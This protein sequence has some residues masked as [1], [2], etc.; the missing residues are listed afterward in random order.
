MYRA[1]LVVSVIAVF[2]G[3]LA[4][5]ADNSPDDSANISAHLQKDYPTMFNPANATLPH[6]FIA[7]GGDYVGQLW[8]WDSWLGDVALAQISQDKGGPASGN[9]AITYGEGCVLDFLHYTNADGFCPITVQANGDPKSYVPTPGFKTNMHKPVLA[10]H[11]AFLTQL[12][13]GDAEWLREAFPRLQAFLANYRTNSFDAD[14]GLY[15]WQDDAGIGVDNDP[16]TFYRPNGSS[17]SIFLNCLMYKELKAMAYLCASLKLPA[18]TGADYDKEA[19][20]LKTAIQKNCWDERDGF[21]YSVDLNLLPKNRPV[22]HYMCNYFSIHS[23]HPRDYPCLI[24]RIEIWSGFMAMWAGIATQD[25]AKRMVEE[26]LKNP[27]TFGAEYG[28]RSLSKMEKM[29]G[30]HFSSN[31]SNWQG[32]VWGVA[33]YMTFRGLLNYG[34]HHEAA[35]LADRTIKLFG[36]DFAKTG[37]IHES[38]N[39]DNGAPIGGTYQSWNYLVANMLAWKEHRTVVGEF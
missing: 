15:F 39:P 27:K 37:A 14:S 5:G 9:D 34:F 1:H 30:I 11:A 19:E 6:P 13:K 2:A 22:D 21:Y 29:Y 33:N 23:G 24:Q 3:S 10:Q 36:Q 16:C 7:P 12:N 26:H 17:G 32:P 31:P 4:H 8:D 20:E 18:Q 38:Y 28:V 25:Q 35:D